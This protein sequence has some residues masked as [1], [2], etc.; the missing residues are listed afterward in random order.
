MFCT[1]MHIRERAMPCCLP[2]VAARA[3][4]STLASLFPR[5]TQTR[6]RRAVLRRKC[7]IP[8]VCTLQLRLGNG[9]T[10]IWLTEGA[11]YA[12]AHRTH[13]PT[14][15]THPPHPAVYA[16]GRVCISI[17]HNP[18]DDP[19]GYESA[20]ER[21]SPAQSVRMQTK[22]SLLSCACIPACLLAVVQCVCPRAKTL[23]K[24]DG[25]TLAFL[26]P[27]T[28]TCKYT[29]VHTVCLQTHTPIRTHRHT[30]THTITQS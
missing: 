14:H 8:M 12:Y 16:D 19:N 3:G 1:R 11:Q 2:T 5:T 25:S 21:W 6:P 24:A 30:Q 28:C 4:S 7:G 20:A 17:L 29:Y 10:H 18:G 15:T 27:S 9:K 13:T 26:N 23:K 22:F